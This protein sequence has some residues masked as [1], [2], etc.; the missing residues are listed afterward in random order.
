VILQMSVSLKSAN[1][2][3]IISLTFSL[4]IQRCCNVEVVAV[5]PIVAQRHF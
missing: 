5:Y 4:T 3:D 2:L 1:T